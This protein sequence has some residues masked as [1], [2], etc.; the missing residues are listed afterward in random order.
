[1]KR[2]L[3]LLDD[4]QETSSLFHAT[5]FQNQSLHAIP[6]RVQRAMR[7]LGAEVGHQGVKNPRQVLRQSRRFAQSSRQSRE[8]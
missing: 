6:I 2:V 5:R 3:V 8:L 4:S 1:M 7:L